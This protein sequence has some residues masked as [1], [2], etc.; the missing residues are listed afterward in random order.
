[1]KIL[2]VDAGATWIKAGLFSEAM[3]LEK[4]AQTPSGAPQGVEAYIASIGAAAA[5]VGQGDVVGLAMPGTFSRDGETLRYAANVKGLMLRDSTSLSVAVVAQQLTMNRIVANNDAACAALA[6]WQIG[7]CGGD[8]TRSL[9]HVTWGTGIGT[10]F[11]S[12]GAAQ[13]GWEGGHMPLTWET[14][15]SIPCNCGSARDIEAFCAVPNLTARAR[16]S[17]EELLAAAERGE[18]LPEQVLQD[19]L[20]WLARGL[21]MMSVVVYPSMV[22]IGGGFMASDWLLAKL[23]EHVAAE[24]SGYL[25]DALRPDMVQRAA[26]GNDAG[27]IGAAMMAQKRFG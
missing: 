14:T 7:A 23:R 1:M 24:A 15:S 16:L 8:P 4:L 17:P 10:A 13:Y 6:E 19:A 27:M 22:T 21:H 3:V 20:R 26:L 18:E 11:V 12:D 2:G 9:L 25:A 5:Q